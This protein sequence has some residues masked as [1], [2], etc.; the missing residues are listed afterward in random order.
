MD[1]IRIS[2]PLYLLH[3]PLKQN[4]YK[5]PYCFR[6][7]CELDRQV[8]KLLSGRGLKR[9]YVIKL[10]LYMLTSYMGSHR[11]RSMSMEEV[12]AD[13]EFH[14]PPRFPRFDDFSRE[15]RHTRRRRGPGKG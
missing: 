14:A 11:A 12:V 13:I 10:A 6:P 15:K 9:T 1:A 2:N 8:N 3:N 4:A 7:T 5:P